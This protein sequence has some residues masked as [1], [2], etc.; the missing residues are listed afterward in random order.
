LDHF[1]E[2]SKRKI[3]LLGVRKYKRSGNFNNVTYPQT[4][5]N[6]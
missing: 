1:C 5:E 2:K 6:W 3:S 4:E